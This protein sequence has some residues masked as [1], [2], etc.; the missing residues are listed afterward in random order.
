MI[1]LYGYWR[2]SAAYRVRLALN[3]KGLE[4]QSQS[5]HLVKN[6]GEQHLED[7]KEL[8]PNQLVPTLQD[9]DFIL[10][11]SLTII[12]YLEQKYPNNA[13]FPIDIEAKF[14]AK[15]LANDIAC[16]IHP[17][18]N[19]RVLNYLSTELGVN[20]EQKKQWYQ[21]W[22]KTGFD[23]LENRLAQTSK[24]F[25]VGDDITIVDVCLIPQVYNALRFDVDMSSYPT[26]TKVYNNCNQLTAFIDAAPENQPDAVL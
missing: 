13:L 2:S 18:N 24:R 10:N 8:N 16:D 21:H 7:Y 15:A 6:G 12:E 11:Q 22:V 4:Y 26:I 5:V 3:L 14:L 20:N 9:G 19:L 1:K 23:S 17:L 25:S